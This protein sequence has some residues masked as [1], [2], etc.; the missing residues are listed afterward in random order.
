MR[1][2]VVGQHAEARAETSNNNWLDLESLARVDIT[3]EDPAFPIEHALVS[4][5]LSRRGWRAATP[6]I[7]SIRIYFD[8]ALR[9]QRIHIR[10][11][12][13]D[14]EREQEFLL[15][16]T[17]KD[18]VKR[19]ILRQQWTFSPGGSSEESESY[20]VDLEDV[21]AL[22]LT[23]DPDRGRNRFPATLAELRIA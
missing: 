21:I 4:G 13:L 10:F 11:V 17:H 23:I 15:S 9:L 1:K 5:D 22:D 18:G 7:Q 19:E 6:G 14:H 8:Q 16:Y 12:E 2:Q 3:S 20:F